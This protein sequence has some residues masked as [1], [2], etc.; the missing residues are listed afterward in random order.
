LFE[1]FEKI[2]ISRDYDAIIFQNNSAL[3]LGRKIG[4]NAKKVF[5]L[6]PGIDWKKFQL[7]RKKEPF[8][9]F[10]GSMKMDE[11]LVRLKGIKYLL[12]AAKE[13]KDINFFV[14]GG[15][16]ALEKLK[17]ISP[18]NV[19]FTGPLTGKYLIEI[20][21]R[22][23]IFCLPSL[24]EGFGLSILEAMASGCAI[25]STIDIGQRGI[26]VRPKNSDEIVKAIK[27]FIENKEKALKCGKENRRLAKSFTWNKFFNNL[28]KIYYSIT[29]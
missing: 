4:I 17:N 8:V 12:D 25:V 28:I 20:Y 9:L 10:V 6:Q 1:K 22:A 26:L 14:V 2:F 11:P 13:L 18:K 5:L 29:K 27:Y 7:K 21:A 24:S 3:K 23:Q 19:V 15:G 16:R